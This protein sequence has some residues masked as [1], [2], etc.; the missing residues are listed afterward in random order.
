MFV[1][2]FDT[3]F[4]IVIYDDSCLTHF[5]LISFLAV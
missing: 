1:V 4:K 5:Q 3:M 2:F